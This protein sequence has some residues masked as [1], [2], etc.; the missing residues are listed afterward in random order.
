M[1]ETNTAAERAACACADALTVGGSLQIQDVEAMRERLRR[2]FDGTGPVCVDVG[3]LVTVDTAGV[4]LLVALRLDADRRGRE[5]FFR[6]DS[7]RLDHALDL[8][9]LR[10][11]LYGTVRHGA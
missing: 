10:T 5:L 2:L 9:G 8:L 7:P 11:T 1:S 6:G 4:Q 3:G